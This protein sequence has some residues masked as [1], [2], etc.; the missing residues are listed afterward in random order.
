MHFVY[1]R[2]NFDDWSAWLPKEAV[3]ELVKRIKDLGW[4]SLTGSE[5]EGEAC[6]YEIIEGVN[7]KSKFNAV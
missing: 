1:W 7:V 6:I 5:G 3:D 2:E 4:D